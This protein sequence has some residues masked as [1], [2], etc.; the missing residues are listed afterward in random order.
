[1][2]ILKRKTTLALILL[3]AFSFKLF[4]NESIT[5]TWKGGSLIITA[6]QG[7][8]YAINW[9]D[10][11]AIETIIGTE[12]GNYFHHYYSDTNVYTVSINAL[13]NEC[14][15]THFHS[16]YG[17]E[18]NSLIVTHAP[19]LIAIVCWKQNLT[20]LD[21]SKNTALQILRCNNNQ[22]KNLDVSENIALTELDC[23]VNQLS[24]LNVSNNTALKTLN[25]CNNQLNNLDIS[26][27]TAL[28]ELNCGGNHLS[29]L[30]VSNNSKLIN[31][32]CDKNSITGLDVSN[33]IDLKEFVCYNNNISNLNL[34]NNTA[35]KYLDCENNG[36]K[37]LDVSK[38]TNL[39]EFYCRNNQITNID[40]S[41]NLNLRHFNCSYNQLTTLDIRQYKELYLICSDNRIKKIELNSDEIYYVSI[42]SWDNQLPL[43]ELYFLSN[44]YGVS[45]SS[46][47]GDQR[48]DKIYI[49]PGAD[50]DFSSEKEFGG[51]KT[52][53]TVFK[54]GII[55]SENDYTLNNGIFKFNNKGNYTIS[56]SNKAIYHGWYNYSP[57]VI[58]EVSVREVGIAE[59]QHAMS[60]QI[61][62]NPVSNILYIDLE[63][64][65]TPPEVKI[66]SLQGVLLLQT[67]G[68]QIDVS[69]L[70]AGFYVANVNGINRKIIKQ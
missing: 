37:S 26:T 60:L 47:L 25:C 22:L 46:S 50:V 6:T 13:S 28:T 38:N 4:A 41:K 59:T 45:N 48:L 21:L 53:F 18:L 36:L 3:F 68:N 35:L 11:S 70:P 34:E 43:S 49:P 33:C 66:Y 32:S 2:N 17:Y 8:A 57:E 42:S 12:N 44:V 64:T 20:S 24:T 65:S 58:A 30:N 31:L 39:Y 40:V 23:S 52:V 9:G 63:N 29:S 1:M 14:K 15:F 16:G 54:D 51:V 67:Q 5:F 61:Y 7:K 10:D 55:A 56:M 69:S 19:S 62:P 27:N